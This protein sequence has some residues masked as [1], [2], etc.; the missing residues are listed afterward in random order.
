MATDNGA[1][2][3]TLDGLT[4]ALAAA[5]LTV[6]MSEQLERLRAIN[7]LLGQQ[8][9]D[10]QH[11]AGE[12]SRGRDSAP[13]GG[14]SVLGAIGSFLGG[15]LGLAPLV[16]G[17]ASVF[18]GGDEPSAPPQLV[19]FLKPAA[20]R[21]DAGISGESGAAPFAIDFAQGG[22]PRPVSVAPAQITV[23]VNA[24]DSRSF[25]DHSH[26]IARAV[27]QAMLETT[28]LND[29]IREI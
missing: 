7:D 10:L 21:M 11:L 25:L 8:R 23:Q 24:M 26:D 20:V 3:G 27:R 6:S 4:A 1:N 5:G 12:I 2:R 29:V 18:G 28:V 13:G 9:A 22:A 17:L 16:S 19:P 14:G 15:G